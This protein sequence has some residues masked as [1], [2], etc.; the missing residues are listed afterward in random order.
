MYLCVPTGGSILT[1]TYIT[2]CAP[3]SQCSGSGSVGIPNG[4]IKRGVSCCY[5]D[6]CTPPRPTLP[7]DSSQLNGIVCRTCTSA[8]SLWCYTSDTIQCTGNEDKCLLQT[9]QISGT[10]N[11]KVAIRGCATKSICDL[12]SSSVDVPN[13]KMDLTFKCTSGGFGVHQGLFMVVSITLTTLLL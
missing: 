10:L 4:R 12:G 8:D 1:Q 5:T 2:S 13:L 6:N 9:T 7:G 3:R 11:S